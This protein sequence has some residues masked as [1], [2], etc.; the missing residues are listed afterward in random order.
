VKFLWVSVVLSLLI[1]AQCS[2]KYD[3][4]GYHIPARI[5]VDERIGL[6]VEVEFSSPDE[7]FGKSIRL[8]MDDFAEVRDAPE[9]KFQAARISGVASLAISDGYLFGEVW[10]PKPP[11][12]TSVFAAYDLLLG[13]LT[14]EFEAER[15]YYNPIAQ[16]ISSGLLEKQ[17][18]RIG[19]DVFYARFVSP[20]TELLSC[21]DDGTSR[22]FAGV[23]LI[24]V[25]TFLTTVFSSGNLVIETQI[26]RIPLTPTG[27]I[28]D[29]QLNFLTSEMIAVVEYDEFSTSRRIHFYD[30]DRDI[31]SGV[32]FRERHATILG[33][34]EES[35][36][37]FARGNVF[38]VDVHTF[39]TS[40]IEIC[41]PEMGC[42]VIFD[43]KRSAIIWKRNKYENERG[44]NHIHEMALLDVL[45][46]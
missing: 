9:L 31:W 26:S 6:K 16:T 3:Q 43:H 36:I 14:T 41:P 33:F 22:G 29:F 40:S 32:E 1:V 12:H 27:K 17:S 24:G 28:A 45:R 37:L 25:D 34:S 23:R 8:R 46:R 42:E 44:E 2:S 38:V 5:G 35:L 19:S 18:C 11:P 20:T 39:H 10:P 15:I 21:I 13:K 7:M 4:T 30:I